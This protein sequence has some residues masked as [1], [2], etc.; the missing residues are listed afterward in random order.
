MAVPLAESQVWSCLGSILTI[1]IPLKQ[2]QW[3][4]VWLGEQVLDAHER[5]P[6]GVLSDPLGL[7]QYSQSASLILEAAGYYTIQNQ[8]VR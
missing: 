6:H 3:W 7:I 5:R 8:E 1:A 2:E 4:E